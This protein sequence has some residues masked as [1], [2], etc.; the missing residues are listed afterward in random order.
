VFGQRFR[1]ERREAPAGSLVDA[2]AS[3][4]YKLCRMLRSAALGVAIALVSAGAASA[5]V[6]ARGVEDGLLA[7]NGKG[8]ASV[9]FVRGSALYVSTRS[10]PG[11]WTVAKAA[12]VSPGSGVTAFKVGSTGPVVLVESADSRTLSLVRRRS[13]GWQTIRLAGNLG[14]RLRLGWPG[15]ALDRRGR[16]VVSFTRWNS[17]T[18]DSRLL[19]ARVN[20]KSRVRSRAITSE[21]FPKS[22][23]P[24]PSAPVLFG[25]TVHVIESYGY[26]GVLG[27]LEWFP[28]R[29][30]WTGFG[31]DAG[32]G[33]FPLG[34]VLAGLSP[35][36]VLH[37]AWT[38]SLTSFDTAPVTLAV[39]RKIAS[40]KFVLERA[41]VT[42][43]VL[44]STGPEVAANAWVGRDAF[45]L[46]G[47]QQVWA[48]T[49]VRGKSN[50]EL[51]GWLAGLALAPRGGR[52]LLLGGPDG[53]RWFHTPRMPVTKVTLEATDYGDSV[54]LEGT[55]SGVASGTI[56]IFRER[57]GER[58]RAVGRATIT[59]GSF[60][61]TDRP[62]TRPLLYRAVYTGAGGVPYAS[63]TPQPVGF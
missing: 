3:A 24:P 40:S 27:T 7:L 14:P 41:L 56:R 10:R 17:V 31:L 60:G 39:R 62:S 5:E 43:L 12:A 59:N 44:P 45:G 9:A 25:N 48:G 19:L 23:V 47:D 11:R 33:D 13:V 1:M 18:L 61:F 4:W 26:R 20:A 38:E 21:G 55:V 15:L 58:R 42:A 30:T 22:L 28:E 63:L 49:I 16:P 8:V 32:V 29:K 35:S 2:D 53:L 57:P 50:V 37:A 6:V 46:T 51:D 36:G 54:A 34:P 52:D